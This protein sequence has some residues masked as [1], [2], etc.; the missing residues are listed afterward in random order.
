MSLAGAPAADP[1][2]LASATG[3]A[4]PRRFLALIADT[5]VISLLEAIA[6]GT[7][8]VTRVTSG[9]ATTIGTGSFTSFTTQ[10]TID[11]PWL[12]LVWVTYGAVLEGLFGATIGKGLAGL[13]VTDL[14]GRRIGWQAAIVRNLARLLDVL[15][16]AYLLGGILTLATKR[17]QRLGDRL[18]GTVVVP[19][20][21]VIYPPLPPRVLRRRAIGV[22][23]V[24]ALLLA[25]CGVFA[26]FGRPPLVIEGEKNTSDGVFREGVSSYTLG[27]PSWGTGTVTYPITYELARTS[28]TCRGVITLDWRWDFLG[29]VFS[30][31]QSQCSPPVYP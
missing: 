16:F 30:T 20:A 7:F 24:F 6:N 5:I 9:I 25:F 10:T 17:H 29:W 4:L 8:G 12:A 27:S 22:A 28:Q 31:G 1:I 26:Y 14:E 2:S 23:A 11:W 3:R 15:P 21:A 19:V 18:A 13:R